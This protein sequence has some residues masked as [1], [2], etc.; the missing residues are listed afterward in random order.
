MG[1]QV[2]VLGAGGTVERAPDRAWVVL[3]L[4]H[5]AQ[6][7]GQ[8]GVF[9]LGWGRGEGSVAREAPEKSRI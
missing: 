2:T 6:G 8:G 3:G 9:F 1:R 4:W 5:D 7:T